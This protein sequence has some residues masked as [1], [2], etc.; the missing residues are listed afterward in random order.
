MRQ[1]GDISARSNYLADLLQLLPHQI[2]RAPF[3]SSNKLGRWQDQVSQYPQ[4]RTLTTYTNTFRP[5]IKVLDFII[6]IARDRVANCPPIVYQSIPH[7]GGQDLGRPGVRSRKTPSKFAHFPTSVASPQ[8]Q[9]NA[10]GRIITATNGHP[11]SKPSRLEAHIALWPR[12]G[13]K[14]LP[15]F[16]DLRDKY[17]TNIP[18][19]GEHFCS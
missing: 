13:K 3:R 4:K 6:T 2:T 14:I 18:M 12:P 16:P 9:S 15:L 8:P 19:G 7:C 11:L 17:F 5:Q 10:D 1:E